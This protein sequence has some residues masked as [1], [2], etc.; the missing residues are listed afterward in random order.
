M[1][2]GLCFKQEWMNGDV[3]L[4]IKVVA[5]VHDETKTNSVQTNLQFNFLLE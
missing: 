2:V 1:D 5:E 3:L 4:L